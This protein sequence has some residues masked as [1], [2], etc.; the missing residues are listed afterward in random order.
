M[1][2]NTVVKVDGVSKKFCR[3]LKRSMYYGTV[4]ALKNMIGLSARTGRLRKNEFWALDGVDFELK[5]GQSLG[6]IGK[7]GSGKTTLLRLING[8]L[9]PDK[10]RITVKGKLG[11]LIAVGAGFHPHMSGRE[12]IYL[13]G[14]ILG[15]K[16]TEIEK[17]FDA[18]VDFADIGDFLEAPVATYS[19]GMTVRLGFAIAAYS[20]P[21]IML[22]D[23]VLAVGD[24][25][26][27]LKCYRKI[28]EYIR[29]GGSLILVSHNT[30]LIRNTCERVLWMD[31]GR[32]KELGP[33][34]RV[35]D[36][37]ENSMLKKDAL[38]EKNEK[39]SI[40]NYDPLV[41]IPSVGFLDKRDKVRDDFKVGEPFKV[42]IHFD[43]RR[44][45][46]RPIFTVSIFDLE[47]NQV[48]SNYTS[49]DGYSIDSVS[50]RGYIDFYIER[51]S[52]KAGQYK[53]T[54][55][56]AED[57][58][59]S[60]VVV[61]HDKSHKFLISMKKHTS[62]GVINPFPKWKL[63]LHENNGRIRRDGTKKNKRERS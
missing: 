62:Y 21:E 19:S 13:N 33:T 51:L 61:W 42:R 14:S 55:T 17:S 39:A 57:N 44:K 63:F 3:T 30:K 8:I 12:N 48:V 46:N 1:N 35:C 2:S 31:A 11:G 20:N 6:V 5:R 28:T 59:V 56:F 32:I 26:F 40:F 9:P 22:T 53:C 38:G 60:N 52:L 50:G 7:N 18:I 43:C 49:L 10:G 47:N 41:S 25:Q 45:V 36:L 24:L 29:N 27:V 54:V 16:R 34:Q 58:N 37:Y 15:M 4:D 23:E